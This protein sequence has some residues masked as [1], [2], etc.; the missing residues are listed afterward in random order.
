MNTISKLKLTMRSLGVALLLGTA[1]ATAAVNSGNTTLNRL[2]IK[3]A[4]QNI[5]TGFNPSTTS[6]DVTVDALPVTVSVSAAPAASDATV[7]FSVNGISHGNHSVATLSTSA[8]T[9]VC[10]VASGSAS[11]TYTVTVSANVIEPGRTLHFKGN[12]I[13]FLTNEISKRHGRHY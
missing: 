1:T 5:V 13:T 6:Y 12:L 8:N 7:D 11:S 3:S 2:E 10:K 4:G 9:I